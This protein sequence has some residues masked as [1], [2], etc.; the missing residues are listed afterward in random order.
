MPRHFKVKNYALIQGYGRR[1]SDPEKQRRFLVKLD[2]IDK[3]C[4][5]CDM[6]ITKPSMCDKI[7]GILPGEICLICHA[8]LPHPCADRKGDLIHLMENTLLVQ[9]SPQEGRT[10][11]DTRDER[12]HE[13]LFMRGSDIN[14]AIK[15][16]GSRKWY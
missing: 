4:K 12:H 9:G 6:K 11:G 13:Q 10:G 8:E 3:H 1:K 5:R 7:E 2:K 14:I 15:N 16:T